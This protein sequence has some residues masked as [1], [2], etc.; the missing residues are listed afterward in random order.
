MAENH[1]VWAYAVAESI[2]GGVL[3]GVAGIAGQ[4]VHTVTAA[5]L[6]AAVSTVDLA[7][8]GEQ[9]LRRNLEDLAWLEAAAWAHHHVIE[10]IAR[11][12]PVVP[13]RLA[14]VYRGD[15]SVAAMLAERRYDFE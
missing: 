8:F 5:G 7:D 3:D 15:E 10:A 11:H 6:T 13:M 1:G 4:R 14:T 9:A 12:G 2:Q